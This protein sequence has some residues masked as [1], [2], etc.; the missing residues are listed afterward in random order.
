MD[1]SSQDIKFDKTYHFDKEKKKGILSTLYTNSRFY[2]SMDCWL[3]E[4]MIEYNK[5][6][7]SVR[8]DKL[9]EK[10]SFFENCFSQVMQ[11]S[12]FSIIRLFSQFPNT[13]N[14]Y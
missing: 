7:A 10:N 11:I 1:T 8:E 4:G 12:M 14:N 2:S 13:I 6:C 5:L 9:S 3:K